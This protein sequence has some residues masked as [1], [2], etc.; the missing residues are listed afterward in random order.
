MQTLDAIV[1][2]AGAANLM[3]LCRNEHAT[4]GKNKVMLDVHPAHHPATT[5][6]EFFVHIATIVVGLI[7][8]VGLEQLVELVHR[9]RAEMAGRCDLQA[10]L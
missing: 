8:A 10:G 3:V 9:H 5:W 6:R 4:G 2:G 7:I 1:L